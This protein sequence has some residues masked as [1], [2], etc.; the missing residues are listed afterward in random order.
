MKK[1]KIKPHENYPLYGI[2]LTVIVSTVI[3][4]LLYDVDAIG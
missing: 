3:K 1:T 2:E 4:G